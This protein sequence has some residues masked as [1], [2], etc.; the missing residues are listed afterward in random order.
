MEDQWRS[1]LLDNRLRFIVYALAGFIQNEYSKTITITSIYREGDPGTHG[2]WRAVDIRT[3]NYSDDEIADIINFINKSL[4]YGYGAY[5]TSLYHNV[6]QGEH[7][8]IQ[9]S[10][11]DYTKIIK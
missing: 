7:I 3:W 4:P 5:K 2:C 10:R 8:H 1:P 9:V 11:D 6:G